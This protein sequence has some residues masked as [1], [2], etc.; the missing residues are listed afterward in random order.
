MASRSYLHLNQG[1]FHNDQRMLAQTFAGSTPGALTL[2]SEWLNQSKFTPTKP[3]RGTRVFTPGEI[4]GAFLAVFRS[5]E[6]S[7]FPKTD[8]GLAKERDIPCSNLLNIASSILYSEN[9]ENETWFSE[10]GGSK[11]S[12][13]FY[14][15]GVHIVKSVLSSSVVQ[16][17]SSTSKHRGYSASLDSQNALNQVLCRIRS[18]LYFVEP[19]NPW[20]EVASSRKR[21]REDS[22]LAPQPPSNKFTKK[23]SAQ[24][25]TLSTTAPLAIPD[26]PIGLLGPNQDPKFSPD[27]NFDFDNT[28]R[29]PNGRLSLLDIRIIRT[30]SNGSSQD[31]FDLIGFT[32]R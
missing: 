31:Q 22:I 19:K 11:S 4:A 26:F 13:Y 24:N 6:F 25:S 3:G 18:V 16:D 14:N 29:S 5:P 10:I 7:N 27:P 8:R 17:K 30:N 12:G 9:T 21:A 32:P 15:Q 2:L 23:A 28:P 1:V 20:W